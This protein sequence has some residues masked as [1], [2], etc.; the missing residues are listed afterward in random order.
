MKT[1]KDLVEE[2][3][4]DYAIHGMEPNLRDFDQLQHI[5]FGSD[6]SNSGLVMGLKRMLPENDKL[7]RTRN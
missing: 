4:T 1:T 5:L 7:F 6:D 3:Y 2:A